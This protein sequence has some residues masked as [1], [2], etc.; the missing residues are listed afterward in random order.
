MEGKMNKRSALINSAALVS[1]VLT[2]LY[3]VAIVLMGMKVS[4]TVGEGETAVLVNFK[5][6]TFSRMMNWILLFAMSLFVTVNL[7][8][9]G[10][11]NMYIKS[12]AALVAIALA[13]MELITFIA[14]FARNREGPKWN[15]MCTIDL[16]VFLSRTLVASAATIIA[17]RALKKRASK[18]Q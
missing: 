17:V 3:L 6:L 2:V 5:S 4:F 12:A 18:Q 11:G 7:F 10:F 16:V 15:F 9:L 14:P 8:S 1:S 13:V